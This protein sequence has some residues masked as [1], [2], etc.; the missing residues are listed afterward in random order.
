MKRHVRTQPCEAEDVGLKR[1]SRRCDRDTKAGSVQKRV[2]IKG[3]S[4]SVSF[5]Q[6][7]CTNTVRIT[8]EQRFTHATSGTLIAPP[9]HREN[10]A[11]V[12]QL[13][14]QR[15]LL[16]TLSVV[17]TSVL[18]NNTRLKKSTVIDGECFNPVSVSQ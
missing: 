17:E 3:N 15:R 7:S 4:V 6:L 9:S 12:S 11:R 16:L 18:Q 8:V 13:R 1:F 2:E 10:P 14:M 5:V